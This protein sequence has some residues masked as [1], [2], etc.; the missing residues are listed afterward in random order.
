[1]HLKPGMRVR[2][3]VCTT[4]LVIVRAPAEAVLLECGGAAVIPAGEQ[5]GSDVTLD[6]DDA[7]GTL[8]GKRYSDDGIGLEVLCTKA[9][10]GSLTVAGE[11]LHVKSTKPLPASD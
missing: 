7:E 6:A 1:M 9:G 10:R 3:T 8:I 5:P 11:P 4:E 2:S